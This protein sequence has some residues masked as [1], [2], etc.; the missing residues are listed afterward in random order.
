MA[1]NK[2][3]A[4]AAI[5]AIAAIILAIVGAVMLDPVIRYGKDF[6]VAPICPSGSCVSGRG[7]ATI[8][9]GMIASVS[10]L[11]VLIPAIFCLIC[12]NGAPIPGEHSALA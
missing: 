4:I 12:L 2:L 9:V 7:I 3:V 10:S 1:I 5:A 11:L 8:V 6:V